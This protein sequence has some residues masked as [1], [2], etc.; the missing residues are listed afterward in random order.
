MLAYSY[1]SIDSV[2]VTLNSNC[3]LICNLYRDV[4]NSYLAISI[5]IFRRFGVHYTLQ[6]RKFWAFQTQTIFRNYK[7]ELKSS[8]LHK[9]LDLSRRYRS[10]TP[11]LIW[12]IQMAF[13]RYSYITMSIYTY[14]RCKC[15][16]RILCMD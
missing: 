12:Q 6:L 2:C 16:P 14:T 9:Q 4:T 3:S 10:H 5:A 1:L 15:V 7:I 11:I 8:S 13:L